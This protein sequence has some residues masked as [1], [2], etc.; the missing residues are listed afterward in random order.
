[1]VE[2]FRW[3]TDERLKLNFLWLLHYVTPGSIERAGVEDPNPHHRV[4]FDH[5]VAARRYIGPLAP[6]AAGELWPSRT[7]SASSC[8]P[9]MSNVPAATQRQR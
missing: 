3:R 7:A 8:G 9:G 4:Q 6:V 2:G 5:V 1:M